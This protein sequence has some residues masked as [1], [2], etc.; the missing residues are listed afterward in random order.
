MGGCSARIQPGSRCIGQRLQALAEAVEREPQQ[1]QS[2]MQLDRN[3]LAAFRV[4]YGRGGFRT[5]Y[6]ED[7][8]RLVTA[9]GCMSGVWPAIARV[10]LGDTSVK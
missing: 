2:T 6:R 5:E 1:A 8:C 3:A 4:R 7:E 10:D 9:G